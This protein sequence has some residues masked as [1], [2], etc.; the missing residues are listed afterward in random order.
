M[1][2]TGITD[3]NL[4]ISSKIIESLILEC[5]CDDRIETG[6]FEIHNAD[7][8]VVLSEY[9]GKHGVPDSIIEDAIEEMTV[10]EGKYPERQAFNKEGWLVTFPSKEYRDAAL[11]KKTHYMS[12]PTHGQ[13]GMNLYYKKKGKQR[14]QTAQAV[15]STSPQPG[16]PSTSASPTKIA[17]QDARGSDS[18]DAQEKDTGV[19]GAGGGSDGAPAASRAMADKPT[20]SAG[21]DVEKAKMSGSASEKPDTDPVDKESPLDKQEAPAIDV[22]VV[23]QQPEQYAN[24]SRKFADMKRWVKTPY[25]EYHD[26]D[27][28]VAAVVGLSGEVVPVKGTD[29][30]EYKLFAEKSAK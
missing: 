1:H 3:M 12:D 26:M 29:R 5:E 16:Q 23:T 20:P 11:K 9:M 24:V 2:K 19:G 18:V 13:G 28:N 14:R 17:P 4:N 25:D 8:L 27:G 30:E 21:P 7:H 22:P 15:T 10:H 6:I